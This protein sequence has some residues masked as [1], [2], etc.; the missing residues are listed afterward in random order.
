MSA[1][2]ESIAAAALVLGFACWSQK[3]YAWAALCLAFALLVRETAIVLVA[4]LIVTSAIKDGRRPAVV[5]ALS[6]VPVA[7]WRLFVALRLYSDWGWRAIVTS[8][9]DLGVPFAG[10]AHLVS[11]GSVMFPLL[12]LAA[13]V[14]AVGLMRERSGPLEVA[15]VVYGFVAVSLRYDQIW[16]HLPS[17]ERGT[18]EL[19]VCLL[20]ILVSGRANTTWARRG[21]V[22]LFIALAVYSAALAPDAASTR[23]ALLVIR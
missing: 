1:L 22:A 3:R 10:L 18:F 2:P 15:A 6:L 16:S 11:T 5:L 19:F 20:L 8:P 12:L 17:G 21:L 13:L 7:A 14:A 9:G 4:A 23:A